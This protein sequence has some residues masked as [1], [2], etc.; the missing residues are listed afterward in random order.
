MHV[1]A[2]ILVVPVTCKGSWHL[3][4]VAP[5]LDPGAEAVRGDWTGLGELPSAD[6]LG[7]QMHIHNV[8]NNHNSTLQ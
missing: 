1:S 3:F 4:Q 6:K 7:S 5:L 8:Q 2:P